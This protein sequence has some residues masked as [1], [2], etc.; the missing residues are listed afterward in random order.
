MKLLTDETVARS[1]I[2]LL[3]DQGHDVLDVREAGLAGAED[4]AVSALARSKGRIIIT[5]DKDF[6]DFLR[7]QSASH[8]GAVVLRL[9]DPSPSSTNKALLGMLSAVTEDYLTDK[10]VILTERGFRARKIPPPSRG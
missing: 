6:G 5:H 10:I 1:T 3:R 2:S 8:R 7:L 4:E 9:K